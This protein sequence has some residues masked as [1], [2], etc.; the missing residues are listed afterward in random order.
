MK[1]Y[2]ELMP[3]LKEV[4][5]H[6]V[7]K[8]Y[9]KYHLTAAEFDVV[10]FLANNPEYTRAADI[11]ERRGIVKSQV[12]VS[13]NSLVDRGII[14]KVIDEKDHRSIHLYLCNSANDIVYEGRQAQAFFVETLLQGFT[15]VEQE[16]MRKNIMRFTENLKGFL[17]G[18]R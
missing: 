3:L 8:I 10:M 14:Q 13:V 17:G 9:T 16:R 4:Y 18:N 6:I 11:V 12:S 5:S 2:L 7:S 1:E 15:S